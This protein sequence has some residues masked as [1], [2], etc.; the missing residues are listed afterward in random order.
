MS[1]HSSTLVSVRARYV[2]P[3][4]LLGW[5][6]PLVVHS[7]HVCPLIAPLPFF[8]EA[9]IAAGSYADNQADTFIFVG[10]RLIMHNKAYIRYV[11]DA[12][13]SLETAALP[14]TPGEVIQ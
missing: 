7:S 10:G 13:T 4:A 5:F 8:S 1:S 12:E 14:L 9:K 11:P 6:L 2:L 3:P